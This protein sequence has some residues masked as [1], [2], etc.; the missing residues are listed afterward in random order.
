MPPGRVH[1]R[2]HASQMQLRLNYLRLYDG[3]V[4]K[5]IPS[6]N[7]KYNTSGLKC[8]EKD[9]ACSC[10]QATPFIISLSLFFPYP[11][12]SY[13][14]YGCD[15]R[16]KLLIGR[17]IILHS[18]VIVLLERLQVKVSRTAEAEQDH[19]FLAGLFAP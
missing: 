16:L 17:Y 13:C 19:L 10:L 8:K 12:F 4:P 15:C 2:I 14:R 9:A 11:I 6:I 7:A 1:K 18:A 5:R 3:I